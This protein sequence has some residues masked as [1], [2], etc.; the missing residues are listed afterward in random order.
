MLIL[1][2]IYFN[3]SGQ[4][5]I[6][7]NDGVEHSVPTLTGNDQSIT[8]NLTV[9]GAITANGL[10][11]LN[12]NMTVVGTS[13]HT[14][15]ATFTNA[16]TANGVL[17][18]NGN[19]TVVGTSTYTANQLPAVNGVPT[20]GKSAFG[21]KELF[22]DYTNTATVG[23]VTINKASGRVNVLAAASNVVIANSMVTAN[24]HVMAVASQSDTTGRVT[25][26]VPTAGN[27]TINCIAPTAN[28]SVDFVVFGAD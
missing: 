13:A 21:W 5:C 23:N 19:M 11:T 28:M 14:G 17:T 3:N 26:V 7:G 27:I 6:V 4:L 25:S 24:T 18:A 12:G 20:L 8:G 22:L 9:V 15:N 10:V 16:V 1:P 2:V